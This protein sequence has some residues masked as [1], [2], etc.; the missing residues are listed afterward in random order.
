RVGLTWAGPLC[1]LL[2]TI[3]CIGGVGAWLASVARLPFV[4]GLDRYLP[5]GFARLHPRWG[6]PVLALLV[7]TLG[8]AVF[9][10]LGQAGAS[11]K[12]AY[13]ALVSMAVIVYFIP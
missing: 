4:A 6:T 12:G 10:V 11:V 9:M 13:D 8:A 1:A 2:V 5:R 3:S 7:Q